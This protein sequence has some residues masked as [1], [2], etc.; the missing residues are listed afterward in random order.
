MAKTY[1][2]RHPGI[3]PDSVDERDAISAAFIGVV[4]LPAEFRLKDPGTPIKFQGSF[5]S[6]GGQAGGG[7]KEYQETKETGKIHHFSARSVYAKC[8][9]I[10]GY[11]NLQGTFTR[12]VCK[13]LTNWG[14]EFEKDYP[15]KH[16]IPY[17]EYIKPV[18][19]RD[20]FRT[21]GYVRIRMNPVN[22]ED[23]KQFIYQQRTPVLIAI[24]GDTKGWNT[25]AVKK[26][27]YYVMPP[28]DTGRNWGHLMFV[29]GW[30]KDGSL[31]LRNSWAKNWGDKGYC[32]LPIGYTHLQDAWGLMDLPNDWQEVN[33]KFKNYTL[34]QAKEIVNLFYQ[35]V[36][37]YGHPEPTGEEVEHHLKAIVAG[38]PLVGVWD[39]FNFWMRKNVS[40]KG[41]KVVLELIDDLILQ[42]QEVKEHISK[43]K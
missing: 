6:C 3:Y 2:L 24:T 23:V 17:N 10:D 9:E 18:K 42:L 22:F 28:D 40:Q 41:N 1:R 12:I 29:V 27:N 38:I 35:I 31:I 4:K 25:A 15:E 11:P 36:M 21:K 14:I 33:E 37:S 5:P 26:N 34:D 8:K 19:L 30:Q 43:K 20:E 13:V 32:Y 7:L 16:D 39:G